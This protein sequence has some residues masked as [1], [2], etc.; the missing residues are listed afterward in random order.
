MR[1]D[2][3]MNV[4]DILK[5]RGAVGFDVNDVKRVVALDTTGF[6]ELHEDENAT[7][8]IRARNNK[9]QL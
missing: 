4:S 1:R 5:F 9:A 6:L 3:F 2:G 7:L 8:W